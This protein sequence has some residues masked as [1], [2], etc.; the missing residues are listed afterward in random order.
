VNFFQHE[1]FRP[2]RVI[3]SACA[4]ALCVGLATSPPL[5][6]AQIGTED[7]GAVVYRRGLL[8]SGAVL[9]GD[10]ETGVRVEGAA[11]ACITCH[12]P[13]GL[14]TSEGGIVVPPII[15]K[16]LFR[17]H[18]TNVKDIDTV[19]VLGYRST[20]EPYTDVTLAHAIRAGIGPNGRTLN[21][22][23]PRYNLDAETMASLIAYLKSLTSGP[24]PGVSDEV[25]DFATIITPDAD[26]VETKGMLDV[27][28]HFFADKNS[29]IRGGIRPMHATREI[30][31]RVSRRWQLHEWR[32][33]GAP[34]EW[35]RQLDALLAA[36]PVFAV[37]SGLGGGNW[38]PVHRFCQRASVPCL[39]PNVGLPIVAEGDFYPVYLSRGVL[40]EADLIA[41]QLAGRQNQLRRVVQIYREGDIGEEASAALTGQPALSGL[42][43][44]R[45][46]LRGTPGNGGDLTEVVQD[47]GPNDA[48]VLW[49]RP[50]DLA[51]LPTTAS[52]S[53]AAFMSGSMGGYEHSPLP[54][55]W[56]SQLRMAYPI[57]LPDARS[58][59][60][61]FPLSWFNIHHI[62]IVAERVQTDTY[63][64][65]GVVAETLTDM[66]DSFVR[67]YLVERVETMLSHRLVN[68]YYP[69][70]SLAPGQRFASKGGYIVHFAAPTGTQIVADT[71]WTVP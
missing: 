21:Y 25:L 71:E 14:G 59:R 33:T 55:A 30:Q 19:H 62:P 54:Q 56:R 68:G 20:R 49:L 23:M 69:R 64:A 4:M 35:G 47:I 45:R 11:A 42:T 65:C 27:I 41:A 3:A 50:Q 1:W 9:V 60:M 28:E 29:F 48:L 15:G 31:Y 58:V 32:L 37:V 38:E 10:R 63:V 36:E 6:A 17:S 67:D 22:L 5:W 53:A 13:S 39:F 46:S 61:N 16:Y 34:S 8:P 52:K 57:D 43:F 44:E 66:L 26:P 40:L 24:V 18:A 70:L 12:R 2:L 7:A 51:K